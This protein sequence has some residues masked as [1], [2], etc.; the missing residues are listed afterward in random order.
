VGN[1]EPVEGFVGIK[2]MV[3]SV[4]GVVA[5]LFLTVTPAL[6]TSSSSDTLSLTDVSTECAVLDDDFQRTRCAA[7]V[8]SAFRVANGLSPVYADPALVQAAQN[9]SHY[10]VSNADSSTQSNHHEESPNLPGFT[11]I[12][13]WDRIR[14]A[15]FNS[16]GYFGEVLVLAPQNLVMDPVDFVVSMLLE[17]VYHR[18]VL[19][20]PDLDR[21]GMGYAVSP[22]YRQVVTMDVGCLS[23][24]PLPDARV[25]IPLQNDA[26]VSQLDNE[27]PY[28]YLD[29]GAYGAP[30]SLHENHVK[31]DPHTAQI[32][33]YDL[34]SGIPV[35][36]VPVLS[37]AEPGGSLDG[38]I[39]FSTRQP[40][41]PGHEYKVAITAPSD[42][43]TVYDAW[44]FT[45]G[46]RNSMR[47]LEPSPDGE[48]VIAHDTSAAPNV[49]SLYRWTWAAPNG[50]TA[51]G[52]S[53]S[54]ADGSIP[55]SPPPPPGSV[56]HLWGTMHD[57]QDA[58]T[59]IPGGD[60]TDGNAPVF[61]NGFALLAAAIPDVVGS[62]LQNENY[63]PPTGDSY[64][65]TTHGLMVW[66]SRDNLLVFTDGT[67]VWRYNNGGV[68]R[69]S[70]RDGLFN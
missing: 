69:Y 45:V 64:Q 14:H 61:K 56:V 29:K 55:M 31:M 62:P 6:A 1:I 15:G 63:L 66:R 17:N 23:N 58:W 42:G 3:L 33:M 57:E 43:G 68:V 30:I 39:Y 37:G 28:P 7:A 21:V 35:E 27:V 20:Y 11:G 50:R 52:T 67:E 49:W 41:V 10:L 65:R 51:S 46:V 4:L 22:S 26:T 60:I 48:G 13:V 40:M 12:N 18:K 70:I 47:W 24:K 44:R 53:M 32:K 5:G 19:L 16:S 38:D 34:T 9:H 59:V 8:L 54:R 2:Q 36:T 25:R